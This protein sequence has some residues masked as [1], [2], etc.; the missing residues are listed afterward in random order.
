MV[1]WTFIGKYLR[2]LW[3]Q[4]LKGKY[5]YGIRHGQIFKMSMEPIA[6]MSPNDII[7]IYRQIFKLSMEPITYRKRYPQCYR[8]S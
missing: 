5:A 2:C 1:L 4:S 7:D 6:K 8:Q 3:R